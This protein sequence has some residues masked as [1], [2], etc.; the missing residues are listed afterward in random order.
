MRQYNDNNNLTHVY[1]E[2]R[3]KPMEGNIS[4]DKQA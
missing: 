1:M 3:A 4:M 2:A